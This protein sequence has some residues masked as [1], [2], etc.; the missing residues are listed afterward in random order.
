M[1]YSSTNEIPNYVKK[2]SSLVQRQWMHVFN[3]VY[4]STNGN[5]KRSMMAANSILKKRLSSGKEMHSVDY[6]NCIIDDWLGNLK[7]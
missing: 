1:P 3:S 4:K 2:Y 7:S 5:E 6:M